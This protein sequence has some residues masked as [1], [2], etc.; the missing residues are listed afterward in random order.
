MAKTT[1]K[2]K[3]YARRV[4]KKSSIVAAV[5]SLIPRAD[6][7]KVTYGLNAITIG[8]NT[9]VLGTGAMAF[10]DYL[11]NNS[12][13]I[14]TGTG[15]QSRLGNH[16]TMKYLDVDLMLNLASSVGVRLII[17]KNRLTSEIANLSSNA[18]LTAYIESAT[19]GVFNQVDFGGTPAAQAYH[20]ATADVKG[21]T[22]LKDVKLVGQEPA[23]STTYFPLRMRVPLNMERLYNTGGTVESG[24]WFIY[25]CA[26]GAPATVSGTIRCVWTDQ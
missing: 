3:R 6:L 14:T 18:N 8:T 9:G 20:Y 5:K 13:H 22:V 4:I 7:R 17:G 2:R 23:S 1:N 11:L 26:T 21:F 12:G 10:N 19:G 16:I 15:L 24:D 25:L